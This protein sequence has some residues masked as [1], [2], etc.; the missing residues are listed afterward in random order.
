MKR[1]VLMIFTLGALLFGFTQPAFATSVILSV[2]A[3]C[4]GSNNWCWAACDKMIIQYLKGSSPSMQT[5]A[6]QF[7]DPDQ[8][9]G[10]IIEKAREALNYYN[11]VNSLQ[12]NCLTYLGVQ[13][14]LNNKR[15][16]FCRLQEA[17]GLI[18][19]HAVVLR[20]YDTSTSFVLY[21]DPDDGLGHGTSYSNFVS[22]VK[23]DGQ[24]SDWNGSIF[25]NH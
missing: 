19:G 2:P 9:G 10:A 3:Y 25:D 22:G 1:T 24:H 23:Y 5:L 18:Y 11:V 15:P 13:S 16:I 20:G 7:G 8:G 12:Y 17:E 6:D 14:Q 4:Q 21:L